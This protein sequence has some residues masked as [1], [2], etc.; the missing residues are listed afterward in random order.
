M[1]KR[2]Y[3]RKWQK[4]K[5]DQHWYIYREQSKKVS[6]PINE[7]KTEFYSQKIINYQSDANKL[8]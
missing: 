4:S 1:L 2:R 8:F 5:L 3:E 6:K 7:T